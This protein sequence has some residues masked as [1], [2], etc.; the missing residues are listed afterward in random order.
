MHVTK[1]RDHPE[2]EVRAN[3]GFSKERILEKLSDDGV[4]H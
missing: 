2:T 3:S 1:N 4:L